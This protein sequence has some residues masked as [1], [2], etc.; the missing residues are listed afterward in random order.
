MILSEI[1]AED[2]KR[3]GGGGRY[4]DSEEG[5]EWIHTLLYLEWGSRREVSAEG[6]NGSE[7]CCEIEM[8]IGSYEE[9]EGGEREWKGAEESHHEYIMHTLLLGIARAK[10]W[11]VKYEMWG[12]KPWWVLCTETGMLTE[13]RILE[14][15]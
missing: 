10:S 12:G 11:K 2:V 14:R 1:R 8:D 5:R 15:E 6:D 9:G 3:I 4:D 13:R 7:N